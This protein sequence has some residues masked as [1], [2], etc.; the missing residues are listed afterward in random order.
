[1]SIYDVDMQS[2][3]DKTWRRSGSDISDWFNYGFDEISWEAYCARRR[4][5]TTV[6]ADLK[7]N[8][9]VRYILAWLLPSKSNLLQNLAG[10]SEEMLQN[11][12]PPELRSMLI[13]QSARMGLQ[14]Q[15]QQ[16]QMNFHPQ[17]GG[18]PPQGGFPMQMMHPGMGM[19][20]DMMGVGMPPQMGMGGP[21]MGM[22]VGPGMPDGSGAPMHNSIMGAPGGMNS[23]QTGE[24]AGAIQQSQGPHGSE[25]GFPMQ[26]GHFSPQSMGM[27]QGVGGDFS[28]T[29]SGVQN[30]GSGMQVSGIEW[31]RIKTL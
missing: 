9:M 15:Q 13:A 10:M 8:V 20:P 19:A 31:R 28:N 26:M 22:G 29:G 16:Q 30:M 1:M 6:G 12:V 4:E 3:A 25:G 23:P 21:G 27:N 5:M 2:L 14:Q 11:S 24:D 17:F 18:P 7:A